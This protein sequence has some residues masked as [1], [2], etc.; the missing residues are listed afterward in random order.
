[1][2]QHPID[3][4]M[5]I[6]ISSTTFVGLTGV[7]IGQTLQGNH[8]SV[9]KRK[10]LRAWLVFLPLA[11]GVIAIMCAISWLSRQSL[12]D[13]LISEVFFGVQ[14]ISFWIIALSFWVI[15]R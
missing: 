4:M 14:M 5:A 10:K 9:V 15:K 3:L 13:A 1:M 6:I 11:S 8:L 7:V 2:I 12:W